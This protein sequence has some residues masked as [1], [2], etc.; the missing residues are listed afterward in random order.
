MTCELLGSLKGSVEKGARTV[1][2]SSNESRRHD[3]WVD[4]RDWFCLEEGDQE[5]VERELRA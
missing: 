1:L 3:G 5:M 2:G 4:K